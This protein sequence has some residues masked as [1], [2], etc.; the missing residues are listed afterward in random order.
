M[1]PE[2]GLRR[3]HDHPASLRMCILTYLC[4]KHAVWHYSAGR[5]MLRKRGNLPRKVYEGLRETDL[6]EDLVA[7]HGLLAT[8]VEENVGLFLGIFFVSDD[9]AAMFES[10]IEY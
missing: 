9:W 10:R 5:M 6:S 8:S 4:R 1:D 7:R 2:I 3:D